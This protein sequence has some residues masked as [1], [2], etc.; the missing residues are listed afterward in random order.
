MLV[1]FWCVD[2]VLLRIFL[3]PKT[4]INANFF[5]NQCLQP[6]KLLLAQREGGPDKFL[7]HMDNAR[8]H[9]AH[10]TKEF[11][12]DSPFEVL[13]QPPYSPDVAP[14]DFYMF[15]AMKSK[16]KGLDAK[17][18][19][20]LTGAVDAFLNSLNRTRLLPVFRNWMKRLTKV[21]ETGEYYSDSN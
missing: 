6:L 8:P 18:L 1:V 17:T 9:T 4:T 14:S 3:P 19:A 10:L 21:A 2:G 12:A 5:T 20:Q 15:G 16:L 7:L 11:L 13:P